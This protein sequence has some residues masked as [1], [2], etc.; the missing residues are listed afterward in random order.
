MYQSFDPWS[1]RFAVF[2]LVL[3]SRDLQINQRSYFIDAIRL[4]FVLTA[5]SETPR[6]QTK[7]EEAVF[8]GETRLNA[9]DFW[10]RYPDYLADE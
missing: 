8:C 3:Q 7:N 9:W 5:G 2:P 4:L 6:T 10:M 1:T